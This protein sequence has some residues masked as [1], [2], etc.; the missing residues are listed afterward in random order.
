M[1]G[2]GANMSMLYAIP[3]AVTPVLVTLGTARPPILEASAP[4][5]P[6]LSAGVAVGGAAT[7]VEQESACDVGTGAGAKGIL[8]SALPL[9]T[10][11]LVYP[12]ACCAVGRLLI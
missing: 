11:A 6:V 1:V 2:Q 8:C 7:A 9:T 12:M 3:A 10:A 5:Q 4:A